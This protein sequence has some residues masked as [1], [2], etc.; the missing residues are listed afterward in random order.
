[1]GKTTLARLCAKALGIPFL[2]TGAMF[3]ATALTLGD[4]AWDLPGPEL[5]ERLKS[6]TFALEAS[7]QDSILLCRGVPVGD[8]VRTEQAGVWASRIAARPE[9][10]EYQKAAQR[11][12][13]AATPLV[14]E[15]RDMGSVVFPDARRKFFLDADA[16]IRAVR[17]AD[18][19]RAM[20]QEA[21]VVRIETDIRERD[22]LDRTRPVAPLVPAPDAII[23]DTSHM[24]LDEVFAMIMSA[25]R[26]T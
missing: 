21:D 11:A 20:G 8:E 23:V 25:I 15:G 1:V 24:T 14:A 12:V 19:L 5:E 10:R 6:I 7:G 18:Q 3:R 13:G 2:D 17:R 4:G 22:H 9:V 16:R 26:E